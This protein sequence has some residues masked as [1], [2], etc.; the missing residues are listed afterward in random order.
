MQL[1]LQLVNIAS[2][3][4]NNTKLVHTTGTYN[5]IQIVHLYIQLVHRTS[6]YN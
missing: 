4:N 6:T 5:Y 3:Y 1:V 2:T